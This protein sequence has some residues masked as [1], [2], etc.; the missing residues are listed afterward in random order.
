MTAE[1][2]A[3]FQQAAAIEGRSVAQFITAHM[4]GIASEIVNQSS[5]IRLDA[6]QSRQF[7]EALLSAPGKPTPALKR[8]LSRHRRQVLEN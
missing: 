2:K 5:Q 1:D 7:V 3:L 6:G 8:A 4:R